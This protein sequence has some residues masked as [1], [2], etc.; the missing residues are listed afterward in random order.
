MIIVILFAFLAGLVTILSPCILSIAPILLTAGANHNYHK[1]LG[2]ITG[3]I[4]SFSFFTLALSAIVQATGISPDIF[5]YLAISVIIFFGLTM[6]VPSL[7]NAFNSLASY[8][9]RMGNIVQE[10]STHIHTNFFSGLI[11]GFALGLLWTPCAGPILATITA[12]AATGGVTFITVLITLAYATGAAIP[13]L[14]FCFGGSKILQSMTSFAPY[15]HTIRKIFGMIVIT[16]A[17]AMIFHVD[18]ILQEK[19]AH[20]FPTITIEQNKLLEEEL[21][22]LRESKGIEPMEQAPEFTGITEWLN[23]EPLTLAQLRGKVVLIDFWT[24]TCINCIRT[25]PHI[26]EWYNKYKNYDFEII[27]VH[28]PEFAFEKSKKNVEDAIKR[29]NITYPVALDNNYQTW[30]AY[31]NHYWPAHY[32]I[33]KNGTIVKKHFGEGG[34]AEMEN[35]IDSLLGIPP[36]KKGE[37]CD[38]TKVITKIITPETYLGFERGDRYQSSLNVQKNIP[39]TYKISGKLSDDQVGLRGNWTVTSTRAQ[40][41]SDSNALELNFTA[42]QV[43][44]VMQSDKPSIITVLLDGKPLSKK[45]HGN[46][47]NSA[48]EIVVHEPR[49]YEVVNLHDDYG[50]HTLTLRCN[51]GLN[52]YVFTFGEENSK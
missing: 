3:L 36:C 26:T 24:Y 14:L 44:L 15:T 18:I 1:P 39:A 21:N 51:K 27:G 35:A 20:W 7:E 13:M 30:R 2:V 40:S 46:D 6:L 12:L 9:A 33:D 43:Y 42:N 28:T 8:I 41:N 22:M 37:E 29:F 38:S 23:S 50:R 11:L 16:S 32:L 48:G 52:A 49:M 34:Y 25:L 10:R 5:R 45:Y 47:M 17:I 31:D 19:I 4:I